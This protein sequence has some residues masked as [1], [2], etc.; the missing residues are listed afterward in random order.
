ML[1]VLG[2]SLRQV[3]TLT[4]SDF[5]HSILHAPTFLV[6]AK[7]RQSD[8][9]PAQPLGLAGFEFFVQFTGKF[10]ASIVREKFSGR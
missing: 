7:I 8:F 5:E 10:T 4:A 1:S 6:F 2:R 3:E 9:F